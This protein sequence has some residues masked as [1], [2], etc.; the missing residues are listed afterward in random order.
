MIA[1]VDSDFGYDADNNVLYIP[2]ETPGQT[3]YPQRGTIFGIDLDDYSITSEHLSA[4]QSSVSL[5]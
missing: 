1:L 2:G 5:G 3:G 4:M